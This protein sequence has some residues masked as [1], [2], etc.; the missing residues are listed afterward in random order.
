MLGN[1]C[2]SILWSGLV[3]IE[4][5][6]YN[7]SDGINITP[8][9]DQLIKFKGAEN[10]QEK[11]DKMIAD[12]NVKASAAY[13]T[14]LNMPQNTIIEHNGEIIATFSDNGSKFYAKNSDGSIARNYHYTDNASIISALQEKYN[15]E[16]NVSSYAK[17]EGPTHSDVYE[18]MYGAP[19]PSNPINTFA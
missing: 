1:S 14:Q 8:N 19:P 15:G 4:M 7:L 13:E 16:L 6:S 9:S 11:L 12:S 3:M 10:P 5:K 18:R 17:G 2:K